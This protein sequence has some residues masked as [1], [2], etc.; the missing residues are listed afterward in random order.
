MQ[1][2]KTQEHGKLT[3]VNILIIQEH[4]S[5]KNMC[6]DLDNPSTYSYA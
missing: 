1:N 4:C 6:F 5:Q 2:K 3:L